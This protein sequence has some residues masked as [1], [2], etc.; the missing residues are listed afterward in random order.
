MRLIICVLLLTLSSLAT[1][2]THYG[3]ITAEVVEHLDANEAMLASA[4]EL[5]ITILFGWS[6]ASHLVGHKK[7]ARCVR[8]ESSSKFLKLLNY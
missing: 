4:Y 3:L 1:A 8:L 2:Q 7:F 6:T 5:W